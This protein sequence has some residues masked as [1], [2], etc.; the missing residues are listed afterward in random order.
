MTV[1]R[2]IGGLMFT[3]VLLPVLGIVWLL[4]GL[5]SWW[6]DSLWPL[7]REIWF[8]L[9]DPAFIPNIGCGGAIRRMHE[10]GLA[11]KAAG[12]G[13]W[14]AAVSHWKEAARLYDIPSMYRL[15]ECFEAGKGVTTSLGAA[16][17]Y[18]SLAALYGMAE[19]LEACER[20][21]EFR[22]SSKQRREFAKTMWT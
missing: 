17:E 3:L 16:Y 1:F 4:G 15:G 21:K 8:S 22:F 10:C 19:A 6:L 5:Y 14:A 7:F 18:Y 2:Y 13:D 11:S 9:A 12:N 20:L